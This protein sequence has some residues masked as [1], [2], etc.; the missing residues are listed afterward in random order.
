MTTT[1]ARYGIS[2]EN[3][4]RF[5]SAKAAEKARAKAAKSLKTAALRNPEQYAEQASRY[6]TAHVVER[7]I[8][9]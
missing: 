7:T 5:R 8:T 4:F 2:C 1:Q 9:G 3:S 6:E